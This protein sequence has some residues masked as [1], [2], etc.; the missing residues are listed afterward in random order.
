MSPVLFWAL[1]T[2]S[3][4]PPSLKLL[5]L[6]S[7]ANASMTTALSGGSLGKLTQ[8]RLSI[9]AV[10]LPVQSASSPQLS[11]KPRTSMHP[12]LPLAPCESCIKLNK[13]E[14]FS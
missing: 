13:P 14:H 12:L 5:L 1:L 7:Q 6:K 10:Q 9:Q 8:T 11:R 3:S 4:V 2:V